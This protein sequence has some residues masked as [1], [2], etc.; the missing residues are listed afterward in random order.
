MNRMFLQTAALLTVALVALHGSQSLWTMA[1][2]DYANGWFG[3]LASQRELFYVA[4][5]SLPLAALVAGALHTGAQPGLRQLTSSSAIVGVLTFVLMAWVAPVGETMIMRLALTDTPTRYSAN[6]WGYWW[7]MYHD[8]LDRVAGELQAEMAD[9]RPFWRTAGV[10]AW[11]PVYA[12]L[13]AF[14]STM[15]GLLLGSALS[16]S[17]AESLRKWRWVA[18]GL[19]IGMM[20]V[21]W[22]AA[23]RLSV[24]Y[25]VPPETSLSLLPM[26]PALLILGLLISHLPSGRTRSA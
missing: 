22:K 2:G 8:G 17:P 15:F 5:L 13:T 1:T 24:T 7:A 6:G 12:S 25:D 9:A 20:A 19:V 18:A 16:Q 3:V 26:V 21:A 14:G 4:G 10:L 11:L 23:W